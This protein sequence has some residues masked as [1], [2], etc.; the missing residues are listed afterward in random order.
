M[1][2]ATSGRLYPELRL[3]AKEVSQA[4]IAVFQAGSQRFQLLQR[5]AIHTDPRISH[6]EPQK[7]L[8]SPDLDEQFA[9][10]RR[11][12][13]A[14]L[15]GVFHQGLKDHCDCFKAAY[16]IKRGDERVNG[17]FPT[18][19]RPIHPADRQ[20]PDGNAEQGQ[21]GF[22]L[23]L[24]ENCRRKGGLHHLYRIRGKGEGVEAPA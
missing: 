12:S 7:L 4:S 8:S 15:D 14:V 5:P 9:T 3:C 17:D 10:F 6:D 1:E 18:L 21:Y 11:G 19:A 20:K 23:E 22:A 24:V 2:T 13:D 16:R